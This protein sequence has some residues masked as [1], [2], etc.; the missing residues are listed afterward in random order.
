MSLPELCLRLP[1]CLCRV[2]RPPGRFLRSHSELRYG[3]YQCPKCHSKLCEL[4]SECGVCGLTLV[5]S[6]HLA[7]SFHHLFP[8]PDFD[9]D[10]EATEGRTT[11]ARADAAGAG[12]AAA[13]ASA[14]ASADATAG[15]AVACR[16]CC[17]LLPAASQLR[18]RCPSCRWIFCIE[19]D[20]YIHS[21]LHNCPGCLST[22]NQQSNSI[23]N[24]DAAD[25]DTAAAQLQQRQRQSDSAK[26]EST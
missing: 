13:A 24:S 8:V 12:T 1:H 20:E 2:R 21:V 23:S 3:G 5:S 14:A 11:D 15:T 22:P 25:R 16:S 7:R 18:L 19:C 17:R 6:P 26:M 10:D 9:I 4:P